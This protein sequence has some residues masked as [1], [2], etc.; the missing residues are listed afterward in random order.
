LYYKGEKMTEGPS[1]PNT[2]FHGYGK[3][4]RRELRRRI[5]P[6]RKV[7]ALDVGT[8]MGQNIALLIGY[9]S[10][11]SEIWTIDPSDEVLVSVKASLGKKGSRVN[12]V[13]ASADRLDFA[14]GFFDLIVSVMVMHHI[15]DARAV[16]RELG[17]VMRSGARLLIVDYKPDAA[18]ELEF[19][20]RHE[21]KDFLEPRLA[22]D[23]IRKLGLACTVNDFGLWYL[24]DARK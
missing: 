1:S 2:D 13:K 18:H 15:E 9:L 16:L 22:G 21:E 23:M 7:R 11:N 19:H 14:D 20:I 10:K 8:G 24:L 4:I 12:F 3:E 17:R 6:N 5:S